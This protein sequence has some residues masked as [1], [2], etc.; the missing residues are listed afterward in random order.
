MEP[1][2]FVSDRRIGKLLFHYF[3][4]FIPARYEK[5]SST[6]QENVSEGVVF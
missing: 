4:L 1:L 5:E 3:L 2:L 6:L